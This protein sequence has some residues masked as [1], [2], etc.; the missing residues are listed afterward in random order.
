MV[1]FFFNNSILRYSFELNGFFPSSS[2]SSLT[3]DMYSDMRMY[4][5]LVNRTEPRRDSMEGVYCEWKR[6]PRD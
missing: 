5:Q 1:V 3:T 2:S 6:V 4:I